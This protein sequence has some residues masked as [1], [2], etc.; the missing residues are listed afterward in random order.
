MCRVLATR[1]P[2]KSLCCLKEGKEERKKQVEEAEWRVKEMEGGVDPTLD[3]NAQEVP[4]C[5][6]NSK[7]KL[8]EEKDL[9]ENE[10]TEGKPLSRQRKQHVQRP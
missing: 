2:G 10:K 5:K 4:P 1:L 3:R 7:L 8:K 6:L 9:G